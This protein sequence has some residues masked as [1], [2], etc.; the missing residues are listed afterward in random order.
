MIPDVLSQ[1]PSAEPTA[2]LIHT[3]AKPTPSPITSE[4][5]VDLW[6]IIEEQKKDVDCQELMEKTPNKENNDLLRTNYIENND[7]LLRG[8]PT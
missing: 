7:I 2:I 1:R 8:V 5:P 4:L 3:S 6:Q